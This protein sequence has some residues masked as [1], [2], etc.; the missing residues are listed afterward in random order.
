MKR[1]VPLVVALLLGACRS[2]RPPAELFVDEAW[3]RLAPVPGQPAAAYFTLRGGDREAR[4]VSVSSPEAQRVELHESRMEGNMSQM[5]PLAEVAVP[6]G[7][8]LAFAPGGRHAM[9]F[10]LSDEVQPFSRIPLHFRFAGAEEL[11]VHAFVLVAGAPAP[12]FMEAEAQASCEPSMRRE[13]GDVIITT[14]GR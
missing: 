7:G 13:G 1:L 3:V 8:G 14:C 2:E 10:G 6:A 9:L 5:R 4:L 12:Q 11:R